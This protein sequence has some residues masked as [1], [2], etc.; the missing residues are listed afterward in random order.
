MSRQIT[1]KNCDSSIIMEDRVDELLKNIN[2]FLRN[3]PTP[4]WMDIIISPSR[5]HAHHQVEFLLKT[6]NY[7]IVT[8]KEGPHIYQV[9]QEVIDLMYLKLREEKDKRVEDRKM[10]GRKD[11]FKK[12]R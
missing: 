1:F 4:L 12:Q 6:P 9:L 5:V 10:V 3:E 7:E 2:H 11:E 8:H